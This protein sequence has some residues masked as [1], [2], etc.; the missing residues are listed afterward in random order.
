MIYTSRSK[1][2]AREQTIIEPIKK[3]W[4]GSLPKHLQYWSTCGNCTAPNTELHQLINSN[5]ITPNQFHGVD[6]K[7]EVFKANSTLNTQA[8]FYQGDLREII[9]QEEKAGRF[10]PGVVFF[11]SPEKM[12]EQHENLLTFSGDLC[13][14]GL[15]L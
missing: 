10:L 5:V 13:L 9:L 3:L 6:H 4:G 7:P 14:Q 15:C 2:L 8:H 12:G 11:D 1:L